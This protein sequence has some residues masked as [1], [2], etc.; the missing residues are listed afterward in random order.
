MVTVPSIVLKLTDSGWICVRQH[1]NMSLK[2][3][4]AI[5][6]TLIDERILFVSTDE[7]EAAGYT[8]QLWMSYGDF[9]AGPVVDLSARIDDGVSEPWQTIG[10]ARDHLKPGK[11]YCYHHVT[12][13]WLLEFEVI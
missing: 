5:R 3:I 1:A 6:E 11:Y 9:G 7:F 4:N 2:H 13:S 10:E 12:L 8:D